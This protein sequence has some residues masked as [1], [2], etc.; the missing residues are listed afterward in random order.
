MQGVTSLYANKQDSINNAFAK[1]ANTFSGCFT[2]SNHIEAGSSYAGTW[3]FSKTMA[4]NVD[5]IQFSEEHSF[6]R[7][8]WRTISLT[9]STSSSLYSGSTI[10]PLALYTL[11]IIKV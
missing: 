1:S 4:F 7:A 6:Q 11:I 3:S 10:Q 5:T 9:G 2:G 8:L